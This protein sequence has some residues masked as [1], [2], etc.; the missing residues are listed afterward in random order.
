MTGTDQDKPP[1]NPGQRKG[2]AKP[3]G[4]KADRQRSP[5]PNRPDRRQ[6][7]SESIA[8]VVS[9]ETFRVE[10]EAS[11]GAPSIEPAVVAAEPASKGALVPI[12]ASPITS[13]MPFDAFW[14]GF[15][16]IADAYRAHTWRSLEQT[17]SLVENL[18]LAPSLDKRVEIQNEYV[19]QACDSFLTD[20]RRIWRLYGEFARQ[21]FKPF[22]GLLTQVTQVAR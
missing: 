21:I 6:D 16:T 5:K 9:A 12:S 8:A 13:A 4:K 17:I 10:S 20:Q 19:K 18:T 14:I 7:E 1:G 3:P 11:I 22:A 15:R 2:K